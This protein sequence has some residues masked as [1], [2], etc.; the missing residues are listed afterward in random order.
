[1]SELLSICIPTFNRAKF[2]EK[3]LVSIFNDVDEF[4]LSPKLVKVYVLDNCSTD[5]TYEVLQKFSN[6]SGR[7]VVRRH[8]EN[9]GAL[10]NIM[11]AHSTG[12]LKYRWVIGDDDS[13]KPGGL[14]KILQLL[15][16]VKPTL[17]ISAESPWM[18]TNVGFDNFKSF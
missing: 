11:L 14:L 10:E 12:G 15:G 13:L 6:R 5:S 3:L 16:V 17:L 8:D 7:L 2:L 18:K 9:I 4:K 1:V